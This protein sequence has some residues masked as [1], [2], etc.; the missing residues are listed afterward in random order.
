[1]LDAAHPDRPVVE[2]L[3]VGDERAFR[4]LVEQHY[5]AMIRVARRH[6]SS[7]EVAEEVVQDTWLAVIAGLARFEGRHG[8]TL[9]TWVFSILVNQARTRGARDHRVVP[10]SSLPGARSAAGDTT[11][12]AV[13]GDRFLPDDH[14]WGGHWSAPPQ[15]VDPTGG[16]VED[17][18]LRRTVEAAIAAL[19]SNQQQVVWLRDVEGWTAAEVCDALELS[20]ANQRVLLHRGRSK[21]RAALERRL[22]A[23]VTA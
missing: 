13:D 4:A 22:D 3:I 5:A 18:E 14:R 8:S 19:P 17:V 16:M 23:A 11:E 9:K 10:F 15:S 2:A 20:E 21:V 7:R 6:V 12:A 1:L